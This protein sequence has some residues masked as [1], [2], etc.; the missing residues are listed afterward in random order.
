MQ[1]P[2]DEALDARK[3]LFH[4]YLGGTVVLAHPVL[5]RDRIHNEV[6]EP[7]FDGVETFYPLRDTLFRT[8]YEAHAKDK[9]WLITAGSDYHAIPNDS[10][11]GNLGAERLKGEALVVILRKV[12]A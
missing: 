11:H 6:L 7:P 8:V 9:G 2:F 4:E 12:K 1:Q 10:K 5:M 3:H